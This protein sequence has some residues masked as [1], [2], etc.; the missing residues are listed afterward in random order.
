[1]LIPHDTTILV[2]D[3]SHMQVLRNRGT[4]AAPDLELLKEQTI[5]NP[6]T[7]AMGTSAP[8]RSFGSAVPKRSAYQN[9]DLH[10]RREDRF[11]H[12]ALQAIASLNREDAPL[13]LIA[14]PHMLGTLRSELDPKR[15][16]QI[17]AEIAKDFAQRDAPDILALLRSYQ[18]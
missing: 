1:M 3:G 4:D 14:P 9:S 11:G 17:L 10:Q 7:S 2:V 16:A 8:G 5:R 15:H 6:P 12:A 18:P 13:I